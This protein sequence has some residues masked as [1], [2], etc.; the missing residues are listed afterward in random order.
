MMTGRP[1]ADEGPVAFQNR[2]CPKVHMMVNLITFSRKG[3]RKDFALG[4]SPMIIGRKPEADIRIP[5]GE[6][7]RAHCEIRLQGGKI[8]VK[9]LGS[10]NG[11]YVNDQKV[12]EASLKAGDHMRVGPVQFTIQVDGKPERISPPGAA[13]KPVAGP[14][15]AASKASPHDVTKRVAPPAPSK[16]ST[17][18]DFDIDDLEELDSE[19]LSDF[20]IDEISDSGV[21]EDI[22]EIADVEEID[23]LEEISEDDLIPDDDSG[24]V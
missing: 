1:R 15:P 2:D 18:D 9:D 19:D 20:D 23:N 12:S 13:P 11:T 16:P 21:I 6:V 4:S 8:L 24:K 14:K 3:A 17:D 10:S 7:S 22:D 5:V